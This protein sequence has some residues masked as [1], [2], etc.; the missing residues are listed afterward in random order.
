MMRITKILYSLV[1]EEPV[2]NC[3]GELTEEAGED[4]NIRPDFSNYRLTRLIIAA[5]V[6]T[7]KIIT[8]YNTPS[9][10]N[11]ISVIGHAWV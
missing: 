7:I 9:P 11:L 3:S 4:Y 6:R 10:V 1:L 8:V 5:S 2:S